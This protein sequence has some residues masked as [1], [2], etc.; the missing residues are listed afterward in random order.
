MS[1]PIVDIRDPYDGL[2]GPER[3]R[4]LVV[5][6][7]PT[8]LRLIAR[9]LGETY[10][11]IIATNGKDA[12]RLA[13]DAPELILLDY[14]LPDI[15]GLDVCRQL[16]ANPLTEEIPV[17]YVTGDQDPHLEAE[18]LQA[19][20]MDFVTKPYSAA[21]LRARIN[22]HVQLKRKS[23]L[24]ALLAERDGLTGVANRRVFDQQLEREWRRGLRHRT[25]LSVVMV[26]AD[27]FKSVNDTWGHLVGDECLRGIARCAAVHLKRPADLL[28]RYGGEEFV[29]LLPETDAGSARALAE[30][31]REEIRTRFAQAS[32]E[33]GEGPCLTA[34]FGCA[35]IIPDE[36]ASP[37]TLLRVADRNLY[38]A[39]TGGRNRVEPAL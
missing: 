6:D 18:G 14:H 12:L 39:K 26:D 19:G 2:T 11:L 10:T 34:S 20:A 4:L 32:A 7:D 5:E 37:E 22:T 24:L 8:S 28:A 31:I 9:I 29:L 17:I 38:L 36:Q 21:V 27:H 3:P 25:P 30:M 16:H 1:A 35:T 23:D 13:A 15:D 33:R